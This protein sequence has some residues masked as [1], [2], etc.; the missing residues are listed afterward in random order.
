MSPLLSARMEFIVAGSPSTG[1]IPVMLWSDSSFTVAGSIL[2]AHVPCPVFV[3]PSEAP[4][5]EPFDNACE[6]LS[7]CLV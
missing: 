3:D 2:Q 5:R 4:W 7:C 1:A 6:S